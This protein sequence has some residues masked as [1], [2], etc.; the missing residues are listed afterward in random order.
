M[1]LHSANLGL[2]LLVSS[3]LRQPLLIRTLVFNIKYPRCSVSCIAKSS[4]LG[5]CL[6][7][8]LSVPTDVTS[9][10]PFV[11][12]CE[13]GTC[14]LLV[15]ASFRAWSLVLEYL[16]GD[17]DP[18]TRATVRFTAQIGTPLRMNCRAINN[19]AGTTLS[20]TP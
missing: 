9:I 16:P 18:N 19:Y 15:I 3:D 1:P 8:S 20:L 2:Y 11:P 17:Q 12:I 13:L 14:F 5:F 7:C 6:D 4:K 10:L